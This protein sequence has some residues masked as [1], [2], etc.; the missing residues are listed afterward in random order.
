MNN[1]DIHSGMRKS[2]NR[3]FGL[4]S[5]CL[6]C[7]FLVS[8][9]SSC[10]SY[11]KAIKEPLKSYGTEHL[12]EEMKT[13]EFNAEFIS[14]RFSAEMQR[15]REKLSFNGQL[16]MK[17]DSIIWITIS[18]ALG[19]EM[20]RL[21]LTNDSIKWLNRLESNY[22]TGSV[23]QLAGSI[24]PLLGFDLVQSLIL[25]NDLT[26]Y[27]NTQFK[28][29]IDH[30]EYKLSV[31][32]RRSLKKQLRADQSTETIPMQ[33]LWLDPETFRI[34]RVAIRDIQDREAKID[35]EYQRFTEVNGF[36]FPSRQDFDIQGS[37]NKLRVSISFQ[38]IDTPES[39]SF[40]F[41]IPEK[42]VSIGN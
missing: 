33:H 4:V 28:G 42:Y 21:V 7:L 12:L 23:E 25:G 11:R 16:R 41:T 22:L 18:P 27:D 19:I 35:A 6:V 26:L 5:Y 9:W 15:N 1:P 3:V 40:P 17:K 39:S 38:R 14:A 20:G 34:T 29:S 31:M 37:G 2:F 8:V 32:N 30:R 24:H 36:L 13:R 10:T